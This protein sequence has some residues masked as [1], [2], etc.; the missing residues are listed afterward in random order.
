[1]Q[2]GGVTYLPATSSPTKLPIMPHL[3]LP[4]LRPNNDIQ[5]LASLHLQLASS[6]QFLRS[7]SRMDRGQIPSFIF[8][9]DTKSQH[10]SFNETVEIEA[11]G[12]VQVHA[13]VRAVGVVGDK[14]E[15]RSAYVKTRMGL[16]GDG[17]VLMWV[18]DECKRANRSRIM[19]G[20]SLTSALPT[21]RSRSVTHLHSTAVP[22]EPIVRP[23]L[24]QGTQDGKDPIYQHFPWEATA[25]ASGGAKI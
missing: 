22:H 20:E 16:Q 13:L 19:C 17:F 7:L 4:R 9:K 21:H 15:V 6:Q 23:V 1:M 24:A 5:S 14:R 2:D 12:T 11:G 8:P 3:I 25:S 10:A 18:L